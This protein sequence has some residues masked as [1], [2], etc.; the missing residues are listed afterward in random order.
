MW[1]PTGILESKPIRK[2][3]GT[4]ASNDQPHTREGEKNLLGNQHW[5]WKDDGDLSQQRILKVKGT[6]ASTQGEIAWEPTMDVET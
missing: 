5:M 4:D 1:K 2:V 6:D 3:K